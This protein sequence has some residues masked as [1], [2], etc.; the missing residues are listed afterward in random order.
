MTGPSYNPILLVQKIG[1]VTAISF[2]LLPLNTQAAS[3][4]VVFP[5]NILLT[6]PE[7]SQQLVVTQLLDSGRTADQTRDVAYT[8]SDDEIV[9]VSSQGVITPKNEG[10][11]TIEVRR[12]SW[13]TKIAVKVQ[14]IRNPIPVSFRGDIQP[15]PVSYT[16][17]TL[18]TI[19]L[20]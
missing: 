13:N 10:Q 9:E 2:L 6:G 8:S 7:S 19:L 1:F 16:H 4:P 11:T 17:L 15:I 20:V 12:G 5:N 14:G 18:P 3:P